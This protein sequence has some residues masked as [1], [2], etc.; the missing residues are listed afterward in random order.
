MIT[1]CV[2]CNSMDIIDI[3]G[4][5]MCNTCGEILNSHTKKD[6][7][8]NI[9]EV[10]LP[11]TN[12]EDIDLDDDIDDIISED[13]IEDDD[14]EDDDFDQIEE[15]KILKETFNYPEGFDEFTE[16]SED[17]IMDKE[18]SWCY[19]DD[20]EGLDE[21]LSYDDFNGEFEEK[22]PGLLVPKKK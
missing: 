15:L 1:K 19:I 7:T 13:I 8:I 10:L 22:Y 14:L 16:K 9:D 11:K 4:V 2:K 6:I 5:L 21:D 3:N 18:G 20:I 12:S 17:D